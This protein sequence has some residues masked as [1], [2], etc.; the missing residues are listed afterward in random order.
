VDGED[1]LNEVSCEVHDVATLL[2]SYFRLLKEP[3]VPKTNYKDLL[4][5]CRTPHK[6]KEA[7]EDAVFA[8]LARIQSPNR[9]CLSLLIQFLREVAQFE[10]INK[11][12]AVNLA[13]CFAPSLL[14]APDDVAPEQALMDMSPAIG[15]L[16]TLIKSNRKMFLPGKEMIKA[17]T[18]HKPKHVLA[19]PPGLS[20][21]K[22]KSSKKTFSFKKTFSL[23][24]RSSKSRT[25]D[26]SPPGL[27]E[28]PDTQPKQPPPMPDRKERSEGSGAGKV[29]TKKNF[30]DSAGIDDKI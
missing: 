29:I 9:Q 13:T 12:S 14:R 28:Q 6:S 16:N 24:M 5:T 10:K 30:R 20:E 7:L 21:P 15:V 26:G 11:M 17:S 23:S 25:G 19:P 3:L 4:D 27:D 18:I 1:V 22:R 8:Q 2:K